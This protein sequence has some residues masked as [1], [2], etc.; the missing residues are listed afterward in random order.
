MFAQRVQLFKSSFTTLER[1]PQLSF[2]DRRVS[3]GDS[4]QVRFADGQARTL[5]VHIVG[6]GS[7]D[8]RQ[9]IAPSSPL[10][11]AILGLRT[12]DETEVIIDGKLRT[13][14]VELIRKAA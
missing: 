6:D 3:V 12:E 9:R 5:I 1:S 8:G 4:V 2:L 10:G 7:A 11:A 13:V 14:I